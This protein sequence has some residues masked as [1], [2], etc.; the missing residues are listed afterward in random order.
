M[1][2]SNSTSLPPDDRR[3]LSVRLSVLQG[4]VAV[5]FV[6]LGVAFWVFQVAQ[7]QKFDEMAENNHHRRLPLPAPRGVLFDRNG[8]VLVENRNTTNLALDREQTGN[9]DETLRL[10]AAAT[11]ADEATM[12][13]TVNRRRKEPTY[14][15]IVLVE[16]ASLAQVIAFR[17]RRLELPGIIQQEVPARQYPQSEMGAHLFGYVGEASEADLTRPEYAGAE[18]GSMV[19]KAGVEQ[20]YNSLLMGKDGDRLVRVNSRGREMGTASRQDPVEGRRIQLTIDADIQRATEEGFAHF[21]Y[22]GAAVI[23]DPRS[24]EVLSFTSLP[25]YNPNQFIGGIGQADWNSLLTNDLKPMQNRALQGRYSPGS[26]FKIAVATAALEEGTVT[27]SFRVFCP[28]GAT[29]YGRFFKCHLKGGHGSVDMRHA[30]EK[31]CNRTSIRS[32]TSWASTRSTNGPRFSGWV[33]EAGS[34]CRAS[35][36]DWCRPRN[37]RRGSCTNGGGPVRRSRSPSARGRST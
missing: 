10:L 18:S 15:P 7:H 17:A 36:R 13:E 34:T 21:G 16:N 29:F 31:S 24:G 11:G 5:V 25:A 32:A 27:P 26:I 22:N 19:G 23:L 9:I 12:R 6:A 20:S 2:S 30:L 28:G 3:S 4:A 8:K 1:S 35:S 33:S 37:G 14:R